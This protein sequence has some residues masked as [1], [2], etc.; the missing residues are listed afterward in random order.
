MELSFDLCCLRTQ[1]A[2][3]IQNTEFA[4]SMELTPRCPRFTNNSTGL[5]SDD[6]QVDSRVHG[7]A[8]ALRGVQGDVDRDGRKAVAWV[9]L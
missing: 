6:P 8:L 7:H 3:G 4:L 9:P 5:D 2:L 1:F